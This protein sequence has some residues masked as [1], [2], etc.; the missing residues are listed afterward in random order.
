MN[1]KLLTSF[2]FILMFFIVTTS[3]AQELKLP[4]LDQSPVDMT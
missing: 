3:Q 2:T 1:K 4:K